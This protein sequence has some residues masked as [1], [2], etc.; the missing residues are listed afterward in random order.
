M[1]TILK[2]EADGTLARLNHIEKGCWIS[3]I[4]PTHQEV[5]L[6]RDEIGV[7]P[8]FIKAALDPEETSHIDHDSE[9]EQTLII[10]DYCMKKNSPI[11]G[12]FTCVTNPFSLIFQKDLLITISIEPNPFVED[13]EA[14]KFRGLNT[15]DKTNFF[16]RLMYAFSQKYQLY[17]RQIEAVSEKVSDKLYRNM[18]NT[19]LSEMMELDKSLI[20]FSASLKAD[21]NTLV[22]ISSGRILPLNEDD[23]DLLDDV[24]IE[25]AQSSDMCAIYTSINERV[26]NGC[27]SILS[28]DMNDIM[29]QLTVITIVMSI[30][31]MIYGF[32]GMNVLDLPLPYVWFPLVLSV[33]SCIIC[34]IYFKVSQK[35]K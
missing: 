21:S 14:G 6:L 35:F 17:L 15:A 1:Y 29:K 23:R 12:L 32:Y 24:M 22:K 30:P 11:K 10:A 8:E 18:N 19:G 5:V 28:N 27:N 4:E 20:Y 34:W 2:T 31:N 3:V 33:V 16:L 13:L 9:E 25:Y 7:L 26:A